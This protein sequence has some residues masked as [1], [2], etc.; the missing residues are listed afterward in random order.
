MQQQQFETLVK[1]AEECFQNWT[2][3]EKA[4]EFRQRKDVFGFIARVYAVHLAGRS[5]PAAYASYLKSKGVAEQGRAL[6]EY[7]PTVCA[8]VPAEDR[9]RLRQRITQYAHV[10]LVLEREGVAPDDTQ[11]WLEDD[12]TIGNQTASGI[13][14]ALRVYS[15]LPEVAERNKTQREEAAAGRARKLA[16]LMKAQAGDAIQANPVRPLSAKPGPV[17]LIA[18][19]QPDGSLAIIKVVDDEGAISS[20]VT[21]HLQ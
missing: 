5:D 20:I 18:N 19:V 17:L 14:Y 12:H 4:R 15:R 21:R 8:F 7:H 10:I 1:E 3:Q 13:D 2:S 6:N 9:R 11:A 16:A